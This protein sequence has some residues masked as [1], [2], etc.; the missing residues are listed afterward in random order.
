M[1]VCFNITGGNTPLDKN[2]TGSNGYYMNKVEDNNIWLD[3]VNP[4][5]QILQN[6]PRRSSNFIRYSCF[7]KQNT[8]A[9]F[10]YYRENCRRNTL[11]FYE[12]F[13]K[14]SRFLWKLQKNTLA[15]YDLK[16]WTFF[17]LESSI[18]KV[19]LQMSKNTSSHFL[20]IVGQLI[21][22]PKLLLF[23][24]L[25]LT[26]FPPSRLEPDKNILGKKVQL[27]SKG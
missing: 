17:F 15:F 23:F 8:S 10:R 11:S 6:L 27:D 24:W 22:G 2:W 20:L 14:H 4:P 21:F 16:L 13:K 26:A 18:Q 5:F 12:N 7:N 25:F 3:K 19:F 9:L 1:C